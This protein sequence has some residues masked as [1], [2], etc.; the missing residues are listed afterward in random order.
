M[1][2]P[3]FTWTLGI[4]LILYVVVMFW[5]SFWA[6]GQIKNREDFLVAGRRLP[7]SLAWATLLATWFGAGTVLTQSNEVMSDGVKMAALDPLGAG[8]CLILAGLFF[9]R[10]LWKMNLLTL[11]DFFRRQYGGATE[12]L[13]AVLMVPGYFGWVAAQLVAMALVLNT[14]FGLD[15][16]EGILLVA[17][18]GMGYTLMGGMW[19]VTLTDAIQIAL[20]LVGL[21]A[22]GFVTLDHLG[23]GNSLVGLRFL[24]EETDPKL[25][26]VIPTASFALAGAW[27]GAFAA[28]ALGN[29]PGQ[30]LTQ[31]IFATKS[32]ST[33]Q[34]ACI[35]AG[36]LYLSFGAIPVMLGLAGNLI[37]FEGTSVV[38]G[39]ATSLFHSRLVLVIFVVALISAVLST[40]DSAILSPS[41]V[42]SENL[43]QKIPQQA[44]SQ[45]ALDRLAVLL[46]TAASVGMAF[47]GKDAYELLEGAYTMPLVGLF[48][49]LALGLYLTPRGQ[50]PAILSMLV[51]LAIWLPD[52]IGE[53]WKLESEA[54]L[55]SFPVS[56][57]AVLGSLLTYLLAH[58]LIGPIE[59]RQPG[60]QVNGSAP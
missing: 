44:L 15:M 1:S 60:E 10:P 29:I 54:Y 34:W 55:G 2:D 16:T 14:F 12:V 26:E 50:A 17:A 30:D 24:L 18:I 11:P 28:G 47:W 20:V 35:V 45:L 42:L 39:L 37:S 59:Q 4:T 21:L 19:S 31:R 56:I 23:H 53:M 27:V 5:I 25:L 33:A 3:T 22:L 8:C 40:I 32:A 38:P 58:Q 9:A 43:L 52:F 49:P 57:A 51:G 13:S 41:S 46:V 36:A 7:L 48:V 6:Q